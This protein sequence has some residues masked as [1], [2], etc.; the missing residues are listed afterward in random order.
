MKRVVVPEL[1]DSD[2]GSPAEVQQTLRELRRVNRWFG[3]TSTTRRMLERVAERVPGRE[4]TLLDVAAGSG[5]VSLEAAAQVDNARIRVTLSDRAST[6]LPR[7]GTPEVVA[8]A[9]A[10]PFRDGSFDLVTCSLLIHHLEPG[11][12]VRFVNEAL[13]V[14]R[15]GVLLNDLRRSP[16]HLALMYAGFAVLHGRL[17]RYDGIASIRRSY[18][19]DELRGIL[20]Q[21]TASAIKIENHFLYRMG[22]M[23]WKEKKG[24]EA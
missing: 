12:I 24:P 19:A 14:C 9:L 3:G 6:H 21:T 17:T 22:I 11:E 5:D 8:D 20:R 13:R 2:A 4:L 15:L 7:N 18:T 23:V 10:L 16:V 1:L